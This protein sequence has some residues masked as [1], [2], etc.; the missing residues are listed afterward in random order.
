MVEN[1]GIDGEKECGDDFEGVC[2]ISVK[3]NG[4]LET[5]SFLPLSKELGVDTDTD[6]D[7][8]EKDV[9]KENEWEGDGDCDVDGVLIA[10]HE[11]VL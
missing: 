11:G 7:G 10:E 6:A 3:R 2:N 9:E 8:G 1:E 4:C 5:W